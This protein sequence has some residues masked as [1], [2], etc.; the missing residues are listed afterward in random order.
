[1]Y[2]PAEISKKKKVIVGMSGGVDSSVAAA[3]LKH[4][5][6][7]VVGV[8][9]KNWADPKYPCPW[10]DDRRDAMRVAAI[11]DIPFQTWDFSREYRAA[12]VSYMIREYAAGRTPNPDVMCNREIKFGIF[13]NKALSLGADFVA[14]GH[15]VR[16][17]PEFSISNS[18]FSNSEKNLGNYEI[19]NSLKIKN[20][21]LK[22]AKDLNKDQSY[23]L[24]TLTQD[25]LKHVLFPIG[26]YTKPEVRKMAAE[27]GL[28]TAEKPDSQGVCFVGE[29]DVVEFLKD[30]IPTEKGKVLT[31]AGKIVGE[32]DGVSFYTIGQRH[33]MGVGGGI[34]F[35]VAEKDIRTNTLVV[36]QG[37]NDNKLFA[38]ELVA[39]DVNW[40]SGVPSFPLKCEARIR[41]RQ[42]LQRCSV[43]RQATSD[44][45][46]SK[47]T[48]HI[49]HVTCHFEEDQRAVTP[50]QSVVFYK[51]GVML[52]GG[53]IA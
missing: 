30:H 28:P 39:I 52:G 3:L 8:F 14:T 2:L 33:G 4:A 17:L 49:S 34:P 32:H 26:D 27:L 25:Q 19:E 43:R 16:L 45:R 53:I 50:G 1:M 29:I 44:K 13:L 40:I 35:Y 31:T 18:Q 36:A 20:Y 51:N 9:M 42:P 6:Y 22:I 37:P 47:G 5:G 48:Y 38:R 11:L 41:Y 10:E 46:Q 7:D 15:Y 23:F 12:V 24:W 21:K